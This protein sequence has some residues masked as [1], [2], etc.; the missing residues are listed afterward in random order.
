MPRVTLLQTNL[1]AGELSPRVYGRVDIDRYPNGAKRIENAIV[2]VQ[3]GARRRNGIGFVEGTQGR[4][5]G[6]AQGR[7]SF[8][9]QRS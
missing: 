2:S 6:A 3:G 1:T 9:T 7:C 8:G 4:G 5:L